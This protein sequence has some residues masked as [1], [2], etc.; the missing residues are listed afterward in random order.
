MKA[1]RSGARP[2]VKWLLSDPKASAALNVN[3]TSKAGST[4]LIAAGMQ[5][6]TDLCDLLLSKGAL[7]NA[8]TDALDS[9][10]SLAVWKN[11]TATVSF[12]LSRGAR[13]DTTDK[14]GESP[15]HD[16]AKHGNCAVL[17]AVLDAPGQ[18]IR[19]TKLNSRNQKGQTP[20][21]CAA[22]N[23]HAD[24]VRLLIGAGADTAVLDDERR[25]AY[26]HAAND[27]CT[28]LLAP[29]MGPAATTTA[30]LFRPGSLFVCLFNRSPPPHLCCP[31]SW[32]VRS[33]AADR[34]R[35]D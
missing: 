35:T 21:M 15:L 27:E 18:H 34:E 1:V 22:I 4:A 5:G 28:R 6:H 7:I 3:H 14:F 25:T 26:D 2:V 9:A 17:T 12:L 19:A 13:V 30:A 31:L 11:H 23:G 10:V 24:A 16:S 20:L 32:S 29:S 8:R 33:L